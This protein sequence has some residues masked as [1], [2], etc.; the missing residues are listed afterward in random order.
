MIEVIW[1]YQ[2][3]TISLILFVLLGAFDGIYFHMIKYKLYKHP[4]AQ[5]EHFLHTLRG[6][7]FLPIALLFF[8][9][10]SAG[11]LLWLG[12]FFYLWISF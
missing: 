6:F 5:F 4:P 2:I 3:A 10:N 8:V 9:W 7:L 1:G 12:L 11:S